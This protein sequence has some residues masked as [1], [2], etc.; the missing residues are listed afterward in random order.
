MGFNN[1]DFVH[2]HVHSEFS[3]FDGLAKI[4]KLALKAR[5]MGCPAIA[6]TDHGNIQ[7]W[8][9]FLQQC[10]VKQDKKGNE[11]PFP[12][13]K[14]ILGCEMYLSRKMD[15]GQN[16]ENSRIKRDKA[17]LHQPDARR[18]NRHLN[19]YAMNWEGYKNLCTLSQSSFTDGFYFDPR[20]DIEYLAKHSEG[21]MGGSAC[22]SS[23]I[24]INLV[25]GRYDK[26]KKIAG[27]FNEIFSGNFFLEIM[28]HGIVEERNIIPDILKMS[29][30]LS[31]PVIATND[32]HY[33]D[34]Y[35]GYS[36]EVL[37]CMSQGRCMKDPRRLQFNH[38]EFYLKSAEEMG[39]MFGS[40]PHVLYNSVNMA[41]RVDTLDIE[42]HL[43]GGMRLPEFDI[44]KGYN[45]AYEYL[46][47]LAWDGM[48]K[49][50]WDQSPIHVDR[51]KMELNDVKVAKDS[52]NYDFATYFLIV[53]D[54]I[55]EAE[56]KGT[57]VGCGRGSGY[58]SVLLRTL[59]ITY[60]VDPIKYGLL[61]ERFLGFDDKRYIRED[62]FGFEIDRIQ[63]AVEKDDLDEEREVSEDLGGVDRY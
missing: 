29:S 31:I 23:I 34:Q 8:I 4:D 35:Q 63:E 52:N 43:F 44:P 20:I 15:I 10:R 49:I 26:A 21:L 36:Q 48:K 39:K 57:L 50:G 16:E 45:N 28:Y 47:E 33:I 9:K 58:A 42:S 54:Y 46:C 38:R 14:P 40:I 60:G 37:M 24:N 30:E 41:E 11:I 53:R 19:I 22:L 55:T 13:I 1:K 25:Y 7:G 56:N 17:K 62:D 12:A 3:Q 51:L 5:E 61:W 2:F 18:G 27:M 32:V 6:L 59:G